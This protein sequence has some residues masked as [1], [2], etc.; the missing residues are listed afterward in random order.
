MQVSKKFTI[1][2]KLTDTN[3]ANDFDDSF[4]DGFQFFLTS[5][6]LDFLIIVLVGVRYCINNILSAS[7]VL[8]SL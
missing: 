2:S 1:A 7:A 4:Q 3:I 5:H 8:L 6:V